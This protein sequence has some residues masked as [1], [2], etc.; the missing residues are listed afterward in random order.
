MSKRPAGDPKD[1]AGGKR[2]HFADES[3][4]G[5][6]HL[7]LVRRLEEMEREN[8]TLKRANAEKDVLLEQYQEWVKSG[9]C[10]RLEMAMDFFAV[11]IMVHCIVSN[12]FNYNCVGQCDVG[13]VLE[14]CGLRTVEFIVECVM[15]VILELLGSWR[16]MWWWHFVCRGGVGNECVWCWD[17][18]C[19]GGVGNEGVWL[20]DF[21]CRGGGGNEGVWLWDFECRGGG[22]NEG[23]WLWDFECRGG[24]GNEGVWLW[25]FECRGGG[26]NEGVWCW[27]FEC[28]GR[29]GNEGVW[30][31][32]GVLSVVD[33]SGGSGLCIVAKLRALWWSG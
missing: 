11:N 1:G 10:T 28:R 25:D 20:W 4:H 12:V 5:P 7:R 23:V 8:R 2:I 33:S 9:N 29:W 32:V 18:E 13:N 14:L 16:C 21:E 17:F 27:D 24:G 26:S 6:E 22:G 19:R 31:F 15:C 30:L 3:I